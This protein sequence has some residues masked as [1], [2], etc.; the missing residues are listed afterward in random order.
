MLYLGGA[1]YVAFR[2]SDRVQAF[3]RHFDQ[4]VREAQVPP[5]RA[6]P[7]FLDSLSL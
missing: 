1:N 2:D 7:G 4:L 5:A 6:L 3:T